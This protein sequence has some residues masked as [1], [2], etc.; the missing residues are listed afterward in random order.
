MTE[1]DQK[2]R[3]IFPEESIYK[4]ATHYNMF[5]GINIPSFIKDWLIKRYSDENENVDKQA[6]FSFLDKHIPSK[7]S[8]I[9]SRLMKGETIQILARIIVESDLKTG[10]FKFSIPDIGIKSNEGRIND[11]VMRSQHGVIKE[12]ENWGIVT[13]DYV[14][15]EGKEKGYAELVKFKP[16]KPYT[17]D[18]EYYCEARKRFSIKDWIDF[19]I[20]CM[21]Y[22][23]YSTQFDSYTQKLLFISRLLVFCEPNLN[24]VELAPKG[25][26]KSYI[27]NNLSKYGWQISGGKITRAKLFY[28]MA[29]NKPGIIPNY[30][31]V[32]MDE[33]K[34]IIFENKEEL[35]GALK[36]Y[37]EQG[38]FTMGQAKQ[39]STAGLILL[40][41]ID[42]DNNRRP[43]SKKYF[44][45]LPEVFHDTALLDRFHGMIEGWYL[46]RI[47]EDLKLDGYSL[48]VEYFS[49]ILSMQ[50]AMARYA[51][52]VT[53]LLDIPKNADIRDTTA[54][55]RMATAYM[56]ILFPY[57]ESVG[58]IKR[59]D[60]ETYCF[61]PSYEKRK[62]IRTQLSI[63]DMEY[64][65][66]MP[67]I[68]VRDF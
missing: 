4:T 5:N 30:E 48:N 55:I 9:K 63:M 7:D 47:T 53:D 67:D 59:E 25:T 38:T 10:L 26:G 58:D 12:G 6:L 14:Q 49:E 36:G 37:L 43:V 62:I 13:L 33:I 54:I 29:A 17:P 50:R 56:K 11:Y 34:T 22:N 3:D 64:S 61:K 68:K 27:F 32:S 23:P 65:P 16:F 46:P 45:E 39:T 1:L 51:S 28:D 21:E 57:V 2:I 31:F 19:I 8:D 60:F 15:P 42:L 66:K 18:F 52:V 24:I 40:G 44:Q 41:N 35:Q 20:K